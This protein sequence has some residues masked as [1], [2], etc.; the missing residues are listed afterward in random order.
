MKQITLYTYN[1]LSDNAKKQAIDNK[2][3]DVM[4][5]VMEHWNREW[6]NSLNRF[7]EITNT[8]L[9]SYDVSY[10]GFYCGRIEF[11]D[12]D[13]L[14]SYEFPLYADEIKGKLLFRY[15]NNKVLPC[16]QQN[17]IFWGKSSYIDGKYHCSKRTSR[18]IT[19]DDECTLTGYIGD[20]P[21]VRTILDYCKEWNKHPEITLKDLYEECYN[22]FLQWWYDDYQGCDDDNF[23]DTELSENSAFEDCLYY[24]DGKEFK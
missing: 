13:L 7:E 5:E 18:I 11:K 10:N 21:L 17:K 4:Y 22:Q 1:E 20:I 9:K 15:L 16:I 24:E 8:E 3:F 23:V 6:L 14:G 19:S 2:R 12:L